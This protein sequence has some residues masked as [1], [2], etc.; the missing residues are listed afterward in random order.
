MTFLILRATERSSRNI[1]ARG[2][3]AAVPNQLPPVNSAVARHQKFV[4]AMSV[5]STGLVA[6]DLDKVVE[7]GHAS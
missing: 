4:A 5:W 6:R 7:G 3:E 1:I 2:W